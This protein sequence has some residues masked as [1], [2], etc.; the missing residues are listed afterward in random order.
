MDVGL[1]IVRVV[2]GGL[3]AGHGA[4]KLFG[5]FGGYGLVPTGGFFEKMGFRPGTLFALLA[6][7][8]EFFGG[9]LQVLG[10]LGPVGPVLLIGVMFV[11]AVAGHLKN[12]LWVT[13][14]GIE[15]P[16][17][18][19]TVAIAQAFTGYGAWSLDAQLGLAATW[20]AIPAWAPIALGFAGG[21]VSLAVRRPA[22]QPT[23][24]A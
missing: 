21:A 6:G 16:L 2:F 23:V 13:S 14:N 9:V 3:M 24:A 11:A 10:I 19:G 1:F 12:G 15:V 7:G 22:A 20:Q 5:W 8:A 18:F 4:Q 17:L